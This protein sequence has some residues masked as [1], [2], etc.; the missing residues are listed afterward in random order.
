MYVVILNTVT[1]QDVS[2]CGTFRMTTHFRTSLLPHFSLL[3]LSVHGCL[4]REQKREKERAELWKGLEEQQERRL[5]SLGE[6]SRNQKNLQERENLNKN[7]PES[8]AANAT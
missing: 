4:Y 7:E 2:V 3:S 5:Q 1:V 6:A 8:S